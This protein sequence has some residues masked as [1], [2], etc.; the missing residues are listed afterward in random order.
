MTCQHRCEGTRLV[1]PGWAQ[2]VSA[3]TA[4]YDRLAGR[5]ACT[6]N[7]PRGNH[8]TLWHVQWQKPL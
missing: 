7:A 4:D 2:A 1:C 3:A 5:Q 8:S 6:W